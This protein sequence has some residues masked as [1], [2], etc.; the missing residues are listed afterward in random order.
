VRQ[1]EN[2]I[3]AALR[4]VGGSLMRGRNGG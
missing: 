2:P 1:A 3:V 4:A